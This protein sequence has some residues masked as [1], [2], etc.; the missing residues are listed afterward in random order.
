MTPEPVDHA[1]IL[2]GYEEIA[3]FYRITVRQA[4][5]QAAIGAIP[6]F[7]VGHLVRA[8]KSTCLT[9]IAAQEAR[10]LRRSKDAG[11]RDGEAAA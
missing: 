9:C 3:A 1:D 7:K 11:E 5:H 8:R 4:K 2:N 6:V 10:G